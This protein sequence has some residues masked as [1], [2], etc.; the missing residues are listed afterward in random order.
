MGG[1]YE[2]AISEADIYAITGQASTIVVESIYKLNEFLFL[3]VYNPEASLTLSEEFPYLQNK[4]FITLA[5]IEKEGINQATA[6][7]FTKGTLHGHTDVILKKKKEIELKAILEP[8]TGQQ[9]VKCVFVEGAPGIGK[10][11]LA[12]EL[13]RRQKEIESMKKYSLVILLQLREKEIQNIQSVD[14]IFK[15]ICQHDKDLQQHVCREVTARIGENVLFILD[16]FDE[17]P[18]GLRKD[19]FFTKLIRGLHL[20]A[21]TVLITSRPSASADLQKCIKNYKHIE[22]IGFTKKKIEQYAKSMLSNEPDILEDFL[23]YVFEN[24]PICGMMYIP[25]NSAIV[26][27]IYRERISSKRFPRTMTELYTELCLTL[28]RRNLE[29]KNHPLANQMG[30]NTVLQDL[31]KCIKEQVA[32]L[33]KLAFDGALNQEINF[34]KLPTGCDDLGFMNVSTGLHL[35]SESYSFLHLTL[36]EFL[37]AYYISQLPPNEQKSK[38]ICNQSELTSTKK[39]HLEVMWTFV[40]GLTGFRHIGWELVHKAICMGPNYSNLFI[41]RCLYEFQNEKETRSICDNLFR[42]QNLVPSVMA[43]TPMDCYLAGYCIAVSGLYDWE[44]R[45]HLFKGEDVI[46]MLGNGLKSA[47]DICGSISLLDLSGSKSTKKLLSSLRDLMHLKTLKEILLINFSNCKLDKD[48]YDELSTF[49]PHLVNL[50]TLLLAQNPG[51]DGVMVKLFL[52]IQLTQLQILDIS[53]VTLGL[54]DVQSLSQ[55]LKSTEHLARLMIGDP[56]ISEE[57]VSLLIKA[58]LSPSSLTHIC[59]DSVIWTTKNVTNFALLENNKNIKVL[60][61]LTFHSEFDDPLDLNPVIPAVAKALHNNDTLLHLGVPPCTK[62]HINDF[63]I[64][65]VCVVALSEMLNVNRHLE[66]LDVYTHLTWNDIQVLG[67]ALQDNTLKLHLCNE[68]IKITNPYY[69]GSDEESDSD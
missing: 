29:K 3:N 32:L 18:I 1:V 34:T 21:C 12:L 35:G 62:P 44:F 54:S 25:L 17:L 6:D 36:Q 69:S 50:R 31:P 15:T 5:I 51:G 49:V 30:G 19:S 20:P 55:L 42:K 68:H 46:E 52:Y 22:V 14:M 39:S 66:H 4:K 45:A 28:L 37:A 58:L 60:H 9:N 65:H 56:Y 10:S 11:T 57:C 24:P 23:R 59:L 13:C 26:L 67:N 47:S 48:A 53:H 27:H 41:N 33:G 63:N 64:E 16:G 61:F 8:P 7:T 43:E 2:V 40:A 38:F